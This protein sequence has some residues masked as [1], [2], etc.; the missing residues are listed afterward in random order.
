MSIEYSHSQNLHSLEGP[1]SALTEL[2]QTE[3]PHSLLDVGCGTGTWIRAA[4]EAGVQKCFGVD[5]VN[6]AAADLLFPEADF[7]VQDLTKPWNLQQRFDVV[8]CLEVG[9][10]LDAIHAVNLVHSL[11]QHADTVYFSAACPDQ[12]GQHH[13][14]CQWPAYWQELF[15]R[16]GFACSDHIRWQIWD[17]EEIEPWYRQNLFQAVKNEELAGSEKRIQPVVHPALLPYLIDSAVKLSDFT[18]VIEQ[19]QMSM[20]WYLTTPFNALAAKLKRKFK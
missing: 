17:R 3:V 1:Q 16:N 7:L 10:H 4:K 15:N 12:P 6:I 11:T 14:N 5:G 13:V 19:G 18:Q 20:S 8:L 9:E 2:F